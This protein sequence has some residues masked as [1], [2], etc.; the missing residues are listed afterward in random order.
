[1]QAASSCDEK[2][3]NSQGTAPKPGAIRRAT[4]PSPEA[5][6]IKIVISEYQFKPTHVQIP[7]NT[8]VIWENLDDSQHSLNEQKGAW[9]SPVLDP[10]NQFALEFGQ[11]GNFKYYC[12]F[13]PLMEASICVSETWPFDFRGEAKLA[14]SAFVKAQPHVRHVEEKHGDVA[15]KLQRGHEVTMAE[16]ASRNDGGTG[17]LDDAVEDEVGVPVSSYR[18][19]ASNVVSLLALAETRVGSR[20]PTP[21][22]GGRGD[23]VSRLQDVD[24]DA[25]W[26]RMSELEGDLHAENRNLE[27]ILEEET[28]HNALARRKLKPLF[29]EVNIVR[30][31]CH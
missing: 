9:S 11:Q 28:Q 26:S 4:T 15:T 5:R 20:S 2:R 17:I 16:H 24:V 1:M 22:S 12:S 8:I 7:P 21:T 13:F 10:Q 19:E 6:Q 25:M 3:Q 31:M 30:T 14:A 27:R 29:H 18:N 23:Q